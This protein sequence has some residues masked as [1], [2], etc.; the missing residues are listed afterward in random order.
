LWGERFIV[1][2]PGSRRVTKYLDRVQQAGPKFTWPA[3]VLSSFLPIPRAIIFVVVG[4]AGMRLVTFFILDAI[5]VLLWAGLLAGLGYTLG[6][7]A[8]VAAKTVSHYSLWFTIGIV[9]LSVLVTLRSQ[10][11]PVAAP[12][13]QHGG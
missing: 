3:M 11:R 10:R 13:A 8:V 2:L 4:W 5:S 6:H 12:D 9:V 1:A 7:H